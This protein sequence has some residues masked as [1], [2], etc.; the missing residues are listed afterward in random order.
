MATE[1]TD[2]DQL[3]SVIRSS[4]WMMRVLT[5]INAS[6]LPDA[7]VGAGALRDLVWG[8]LYGPGFDPAGVRDIDVAYFD[9]DDL[10]R[11]RDEQAT[12]RLEHIWP[13]Q[14]WEARNQAA[15]HTWYNTKFGGEPARPLRSIADAIATWPETA[16]AVVVRLDPAGEIAICAPLGLG[17]LLAG[18]WRRNPERVSLQRS[19]ERLARHRPAQRWPAVTVI[20][21]E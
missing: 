7:W 11:D 6:E 10:S 17:D 14:P 20:P 2:G 13:R 16:T 9:P 5:T 1:T 19:R 4:T 21:P 18:V 15:I 8:E 12:A 3:R